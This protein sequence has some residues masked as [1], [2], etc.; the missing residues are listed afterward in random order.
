MK[1]LSLVKEQAQS[2]LTTIRGMEE[3]EALKFDNPLEQEFV[4]LILEEFV[5]QLRKGSA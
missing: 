5:L 2:L 1:T 4:A 3:S